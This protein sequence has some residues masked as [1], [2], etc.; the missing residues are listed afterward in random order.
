MER[1][2]GSGNDGRRVRWNTDRQQE[3][4]G[5]HHQENQ[6]LRIQHDGLIE[7]G[8]IG[9]EAGLRFLQALRYQLLRDRA[10]VLLV[11]MRAE[12][13]GED[14]GVRQRL[15]REEKTS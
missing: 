11:Q 3:G 15:G 7:H 1:E 9:V 4:E 8:R 13:R 6:R 10:P 12:R 5:Q 2:H 14:I